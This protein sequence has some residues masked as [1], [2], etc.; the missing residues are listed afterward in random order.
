MRI[1]KSSL[2]RILLLFV[3]VI[4]V[5]AV[6]LFNQKGSPTLPDDGPPVQVSQEAAIR[7][8]QKALSSTDTTGSGGVVQFSVTQEEATSALA[9][10]ARMASYSQGGPLFEGIPGLEG[11]AGAED[12]KRMLESQSDSVL[13]NSDL[14]PQ[15]VNLARNMGNRDRGGFSLPDIR[16]KL[17]QP[18]VYFKADGRIILRGYGRLFRWR[19]PMR[20]VVAPAAVE[21]ELV[22]DFVE[23]QLGSIPM[24]EFL[25]DPLGKLLAQVLLAGQEYADITQLAVTS[26][27]LSFAGRLSLAK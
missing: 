3:I 19:I 7:F 8:A 27:R 5:A 25:F 20:V 16:L 15:I 6:Y 17:E 9:I 21:G 22:L 4:V 18:Q 14:P 2:G 11:M 26:S 24:P 10:G 13:E 12:I 1:L 23:G